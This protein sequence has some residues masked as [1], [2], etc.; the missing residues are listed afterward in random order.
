MSPLAAWA[1]DLFEKIFAE[2]LKRE[3]DARTI[4]KLKEQRDEKTALIEKAK[5][6]Y[7]ALRQSYEDAMSR[8][9]YLEAELSR[10]K[11]ELYKALDRGNELTRQL[12]QGTQEVQPIPGAYPGSAPLD[13]TTTCAE[14]GTPDG[15]EE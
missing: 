5:P 1:F 15:G 2:G 8:A 13:W 11:E 3:K 10:T 4:A 7:Y 6:A 14:G 9:E 12:L